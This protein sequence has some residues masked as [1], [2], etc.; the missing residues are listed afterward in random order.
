MENILK[1]QLA[2]EHNYTIIII[3]YYKHNGRKLQVF[4]INIFRIRTK[5]TKIVILHLNI[6]ICQN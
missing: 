1:M 3:V 5:V 4:K 6:K 2:T